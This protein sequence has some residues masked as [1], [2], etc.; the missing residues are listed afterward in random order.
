MNT[1]RVLI[2]DDEEVVCESLTLKIQRLNHPVAYEIM[3]I[4]SGARALRLLEN[5]QFDII[6]TDMRM[7][8]MSGATF[9][10]KARNLE[11]S[12]Y[13]LVLSVYDDYNYVRDA[14]VVGANDYLLKPISV[15]DL[16][17][18][19]RQLL[20]AE[21]KQTQKSEEILAR[22]DKRKSP[23]R[24]SSIDYA[25]EYM[26]VHYVNSTLS[27][28][29]VAAHVSLSYSHF[30]SLFRK[31]TGTTFPAY[32][33]K[34]RIEKAIELLSDPGLRIADVSYRV[35]F[36][37]PQQFS[38]DFKKVTGVYPT[39]YIES[40]QNIRGQQLEYKQDINTT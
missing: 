4:N 20:M 16:D 8:Y 37:Y 15:K 39:E 13:I 29:E 14:F 7:P 33:R 12:G 26:H 6:I 5:M 1:I 32:L 21:N 9:I 36:K 3:S 34:Y 17:V 19:F 2:V 30:S 23:K 18:K 28:N 24:K 35:G 25:L 31:K 11:Y 10:K 40:I 22:P 27:M 38:N